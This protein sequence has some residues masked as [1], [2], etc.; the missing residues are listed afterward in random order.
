MR[1]AAEQRKGEIDMSVWKNGL[2]LAAGGIAGLAMAAWLEAESVS[3]RDRD[4]E[5]SRRKATEADGGEL[6]GE[7]SYGDVVCVDGAFLKRY[8][9]WTG[10]NFILYGADSRGKRCVHEASF[11]DFL[12]G[13]RQF[14]ICEFPEEYGRPV[15]WEQ[16]VPSIIAPPPNIWRMW[17]QM[18][19]EKKY[20]LYPPGETVRRARSKLGAGD[21][22]TSEHFALWCKT[23]ISESHELEDIR[24]FLERGV[25]Y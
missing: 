6:S 8:G 15:Q 9:I 11:R 21:Y 4:E 14:A 20:K 25:V 22:L 10:E 13:A 2:L 1:L 24:R 12:G 19:K 5:S 3:E 18:Y 16:P 7:V 23:G 17:E